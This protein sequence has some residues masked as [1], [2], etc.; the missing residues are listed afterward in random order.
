MGSSFST[1]SRSDKGLVAVPYGCARASVASGDHYPRRR[2]GAVWRCGASLLPICSAPGTRPKNEI[3]VFFSYF[4][5][6]Y[7]FVSG[8]VVPPV[9]AVITEGFM[10]KFP[11]SFFAHFFVFPQFP[12]CPNV[13]MR[14]VPNI[15]SPQFNFRTLE[16]LPV[17]PVFPV[18]LGK[19]QAKMWKNKLFDTNSL[20]GVSGGKKGGKN[21][22]QGRCSWRLPP[23]FRNL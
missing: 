19:K 11:G 14:S 2:L 12:F 22:T 23:G 8:T 20:Q 21:F 3:I 5:T 1:Q 17:F 10:S 15:F 18:I 7:I 16:M 4:E 13:G 9:S 6:F